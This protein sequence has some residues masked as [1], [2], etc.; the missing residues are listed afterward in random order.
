[1]PGST[2]GSDLADLLENRTLPDLIV[3]DPDSQGLRTESLSPGKLAWLRFRHHRA[4]II[5][6]VVLVIMTVLCALAPWIAPYGQNEALGAANFGPPS[7]EFWF[8]TDQ[9]GRDLLSRILWGGRVSLFIG[10]AT[11]IS[12]GLIGTAVGAFAGF[13]GGR[14]DEILMRFTDLFIGL[15]L[16]VVLLIVRQLPNTQPWASTLL[17]PPGSL[18]LMISLLTFVTWM[19]TARLVRGT[20][21]SLKEKE[22]VEAARAIGARD[23]W[24]IGRHLV[25]NSIGPII[26]AMTFAVAG[27]I[28]LESTLSYFGFG[29]DPLKASWGN[30]LADTK[31]AVTSGY[32]WLV[33]FPSLSLLLTILCV[34]FVGDGLRDAVDP[35]QQ[36]EG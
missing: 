35:K 9:I 7:S 11:A 8:G 19:G 30:L 17:G 4:A 1:M 24:I 34:N 18:R 13:R 31:G 5:S 33:V 15:P 16:L 6:L 21:L 10:I 27:A 20:V 32:W 22:F 2:Q 26:V 28:G 14:I 36:L 29:L 12:A 25:P 23:T 3:L